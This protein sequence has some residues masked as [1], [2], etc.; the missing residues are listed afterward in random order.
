M[1]EQLKQYKGPRSLPD[2]SI[3]ELNR[4]AQEIRQFLV[5]TVSQTGGHLAPNLG[6]V[7]LTIALHNVFDFKKDRLVFDVG[8]QSYVHKILTGRVAG[9]KTLRKYQGLSGFPKTKESP[10]DHFNTGHASTSIS[11]ALGM[12][13]ARDIKGENHHV[14]CVIGD[15]AFNGGMV[16]EALNDVGYRQTPM[17]IVLNDNAM[18]I[19][20]NVG[21]MSRYLSQLRSDEHYE[22][23][24]KSFQGRMERLP[25]GKPLSNT[26]RR[27]KDSVKAMVIENEGM[28]FENMGL[29]YL[30]PVDGHNIK[31]MSKILQAA[32]DFDGPSIVHAITQKGRGYDYAVEQPDKFHGIGPFDCKNGRVNSSGTSYSQVFGHTLTCMAEEDPEIVAITAAMPLGTGLVEFSQR[33]PQRFFDVGITEEHAVTLAGGMAISG[34]KPYVAIYSTFLQRCLDQIIHDVAL[35]DLNVTFCV[36]RAGVVG[37]DGETHQGEF[38]IAF[39]SMVPG[40]T[41]MAPKNMDELAAM[42]RW[43]RDFKGPLAIRYPRGGDEPGIELAALR[44]FTPGTWENLPGSHPEEAPVVLIGTGKM[45]ARAFEAARLLQMEGVAA[46]CVHAPFI[47]PL[48]QKLIGKLKNARLIISVEDG[49]LKGGFGES[50][51]S[52]LNTNR[53]EGEFLAMGFDDTFIEQGDVSI[54]YDKYELTP[55]KIRDRAKARLEEIGNGTA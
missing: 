45:S 15:G 2:M 21:S 41:V 1:Y 8:H 18:S 44:E 10:Y 39:L 4:M 31:E 54:I 33:Y 38:D 25:M 19:S 12:A 30:G 9:F 11:A 46:A 16:W 47:K 34:L 43:S 7:E 37:D 53:Y 35:Q 50:I 40:M 27:M 55:E 51:L 52:E 49:I 3:D 29:K 36:D 22:R 26:A 28:L 20:R 32:R 42:M 5:N 14:L 48:D 23:F 13:R 17:I 24:K 6:V